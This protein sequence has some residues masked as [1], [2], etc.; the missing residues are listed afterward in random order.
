V[1]KKNKANASTSSIAQNGENT[2]SRARISDTS[3]LS[4]DKGTDNVSE[5]QEKS[6]FRVV[7]LGTNA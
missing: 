3:A 1:S 6:R 7:Y 2:Q 5:K 4:T